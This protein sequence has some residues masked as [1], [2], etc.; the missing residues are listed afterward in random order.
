MHLQAGINAV[1]ERNL[2]WGLSDVFATTVNYDPDKN[3]VEYY[4]KPGISF[5]DEADGLTGYGKASFVASYTR[6]TDAYDLGDS[7]RATLEEAY[8]GGRMCFGKSLEIDASIGPRELNLGTGMLIANGGSSGFERGALKFG[9]RKAWEM[10]AIGRIRNGEVTGTAFFI[11]P[12]EI[13]STDNANRLAGADLRYDAAADGFAGVTYVYVLNSG[14]A[15]PQ[16][17]PGEDGAPTIVAGAREGLNAINIYG[18]TNPLSAEHGSFFLGLDA[19]LGWNDGIDMLAWGGRLQA[20]HIWSDAS[21]SPSLTYTFKTF[22]GDDP[23]TTRQERFDPLYYDGSPSTWATGSKSSMT[24]I[25]S[26]VRAHELALS[27]NPTARD[28]LTLR[29]AHIRANELRSPVQFGQ[30]ARFEIAGGSNIVTGV[31]DKHLADDAFLE[32]S[33]II[34]PNTFLTAG[35]SASVPG[36]GLDLAAGTDLPIWYGGFV[37]LV[38]NF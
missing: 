20:G 15:Y 25:N 35:V 30:A 1:S 23:D 5:T 13:P 24:F 2:F 18:R 26:N 36:K 33:R 8:L 4:M 19:A 38:I 14:N 27:V 32:Y 17:L 12:N 9:P 3:W 37:N 16:L 34:N 22:S 21:W 6:N 10:A 11:D 31:T 7:G 28:K 29:Y